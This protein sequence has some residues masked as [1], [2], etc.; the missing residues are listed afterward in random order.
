MKKENQSKILEF[1]IPLEK[2]ELL[3]SHTGQYCV[4]EVLPPRAIPQAISDTRAALQ[5]NGVN[6]ILEHFD[7]FFS[8]IVH[9]SKIE[10]SMIT[11]GFDRLMKTLEILVDDLE[12]VFDYGTE[13]IP[14][15]RSRLLCI[16]KMLAYLVS[17][18]M[19]HINGRVQQD[20]GTIDLMGKRKKNAKKSDAEEEWE[21]HKQKSLELIYRWVQQP[22]Q[23][24][25]QPPIAEDSFISVL[26]QI[27][28]TLLEDAKD[29]KQKPLRE[30]IF[31]ILGTLVKRYNHGV[32]C[33][34]KIVQLVKLHDVLAIPL[35]TGIAQIV[36]ET[37]CT[38][39]IK[40]FVREIGQTEAEE[41]DARNISIFLESLSSARPDLLLPILGSITDYLSND[42]YTMRNCVISI[43]G[44]I[45]LGAL[46]GEDLTP[47]QKEKR[48][49]CLDNLEEHI[50]D[51]NAYVRSK[52][53]NTWQKLCC[54]GAVPL[55]RQ[56]SLLK[57]TV[58]RL[59]DKSANVRK[60][61]F[62]LL[63][64][65]LQ[66]NPY[67][68]K[69]NQNE[70]SKQLEDAITKLK[71]LRTEQ[72][73]QSVRGD[74][75]RLQFWN[76]QLPVIRTA[77]KTVLKEE[78]T[79]NEN[80]EDVDEAFEKV[81]QLMLR[82]HVLEAVQ[83]LWHVSAQLPGAPDMRNIDSNSQEECLFLF[84]LKIFMESEASDSNM[85]N[86]N[87]KTT[88]L[89]KSKEKERKRQ[90]DELNAQKRLVEYLKDCSQFAQ[91]L[92][93]AIP[94]AE[95]LLFSTTA[96][97]A[98][99]ACAFLGTACQFRVAG[100][101]NGV[102]KAL[103]QVFSRDQSV[104]DNVAN[105]YK[106]LY[107]G[108]NQ[109]YQS[110]RQRGLASVKAL[111][112]FVMDLEPGQ[113]PALTQLIVSWCNSKDLDA[114]ALQVMWEKFSMKLPDT[115]PEESRAALVL[116]TMAAKGESAIITG[117]LDVLLKIGLGRRAKTDL[118]LARDTCRALHKIPNNNTD[119]NKPPVR[120]ANDHEIFQNI[121]ELL[122]ENFMNLE[123][124]C[125]ISFA[126][127]AI[128]II[129]HLANQPD[130]LIKEMMLDVVAK[131]NF[132][133]N[134]SYSAVAPAPLL[135]RLLYLVGHIAI[136]QMVHLDTAV[137]KEL[138]RRNELREMKRGRKSKKRD[139]LLPESVPNTPSCASQTLR[140][141]E[142]STIEDNGEE[143][144]EGATADDADAEF[145]NATLENDIVTGDGLLAKFVP[146]VLDICRYPDKYND[147][148]V[149]AWGVLALSK[150]MTVSSRFCEESLQLLVTIMERSPYPGIRANVLIGLTDLT[151]RFPNQIEP[152][153]SHIY[154]RL[155]DDNTNVRSTCVRMLSNLIMREM[156]RVKGQVSELA[157]CIVDPDPDIC[158][159]TKQFFRDLSQ[160]GNAL[161]NV[162]P[163]ILSRLSDPELHLEEDK[164]QE[165]LRY[166]LGLLQKERQVDTII[167]KLCARFKL[168]TTER[169]W[170]DLSYC[171][172]LLHFSGKSI[173]R[174]IESLPLLKDKIH[175]REVQRALRSIIDQTKKKPDAKAACLELD[176][177]I[178]EM[179]ENAKTM[180]DRDPDADV[181]PPPR[182]PPRKKMVRKAG[183]QS[184]SEEDDS[185]DDDDPVSTP[186]RYIKSKR[187]SR[188]T[189]QKSD[190][191][192]E[193]DAALA[194]SKTP[195]KR[196]SKTPRRQKILETP[197]TLTT[198]KRSQTSRTPARSST[199]TP[200]RT[201]L[202]L[203]TR[204]ARSKKM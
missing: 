6:F 105:V 40:E 88:E 167:E 32:I 158:Q 181:M 154:G 120:Y 143:A 72:A 66:G 163:D 50:L 63:R 78:N 166:I 180:E 39:M 142:N 164:F 144:L 69:L 173:R 16:N 126:T 119:P 175:H 87:N 21:R 165:V 23:K 118:L 139:T 171:L 198:P 187:K 159:S 13:L 134:G 56:G 182:L 57:A 161:Y 121:L 156:V 47:E 130:K 133:K 138:K 193:E 76:S 20:A 149:Q 128:N 107:L 140:N 135:A 24:L 196:T 54:E 42:Q 62:Q 5:D 125:Y 184:S 84:L 80:I 19:R 176:E 71:Q 55:A 79:A 188:T 2:D 202:R 129:Y 147:E 27:C 34:I 38:G 123:D 131:G 81:R 110:G 152:W 53:L 117:N 97:D 100:A 73:S 122:T 14:E 93:N 8:I 115:T 186:R 106:E 75:E 203:S 17:W 61:A 177:K 200:T 194:F 148:N 70:L 83:Y 45:I 191:D 86:N 52:V 101:I 197:S 179:L 108:T 137:Y 95:H 35:A 146:L 90:K 94:Q 28:Y 9:G 195:S 162:M 168:A 46:T 99:E 31:E 65:L 157:L 59:E 12:K 51:I 151:I 3:Q 160:K 67:A 91:E 29:S 22:L 44:A 103:F 26:T 124:E 92:A 104:Q 18:F 15:D 96:S 25:W 4:N 48:D 77:I 192:S 169:Q 109:Q 112:R 33:V 185:S 189:E 68:A 36:T 111:I 153:T 136:R 1:V 172:S 170:R 49:E 11:R 7:T 145:I 190:S 98:V 74:E 141:K 174:L 199:E 82:E 201:S 43:L 113:S 41:G 116:I 183:K 58:L 114:D 64:A 89:E 127:D 204:S 85:A 150:M 178:K 102:R 60:Q 155:R 10:L 37:G 132:V 30:T